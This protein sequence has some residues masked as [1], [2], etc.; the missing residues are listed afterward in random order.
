MTTDEFLRECEKELSVGILH[1]AWVIYAVSV[2][3]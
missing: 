1:E 2:K 3:G